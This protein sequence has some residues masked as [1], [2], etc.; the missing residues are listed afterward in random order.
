MNDAT[1]TRQEAGRAPSRRSRSLLR[2]AGR[3]LSQAILVL[4]IVVLCNF[5]IMEFA[6]GD[7]VSV[8][9]GGS[10]MSAEQMA[11]LR[12]SF[13]LDRPWPVRLMNYVGQLATFDLG[14]SYR[15][16]A[17]VWDIILQRLPTTLLLILLS[18]SVSLVI[19]TVLGVVAARNAGRI[20]DAAINIVGLLLYATPSFIVGILMILVFSV[21][22]GWFPVAGL[23]TVGSELTGMARFKDIAAHLVLPVASLCS[24]YIAIY[25]RITRATMLEVMDQDFVRTAWAKGLSRTRV[26]YGHTLR[27]AL[28]PLVTMAGMQVSTVL[29]GA[30]VVETVFGLPGMARTAYDAVFQRDTNL[31]LGVM[32]VSALSVVVINLIV[33][34]LYAALDP[35]VELK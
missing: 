6:P 11:A 8:L 29:G 2:F 23:E 17:P 12:D 20:G 24:F 22:L 26:I 18:V 5:T 31:L 28:L 13:G 10:D 19:G 35:R 9:A 14:F 15:N 25:A 30:V 34:L 32:F 33:D 27:N 1:E 3:R 21:W 16:Q 4:L 7:M